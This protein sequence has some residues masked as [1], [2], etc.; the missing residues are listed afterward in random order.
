MNL[1]EVR[2]E[3]E[4][5]TLL[6]DT[7]NTVVEGNEDYIYEPPTGASCYYLHDGKPSCIWGHVLVG[8]DVPEAT[9][10]DLEF[11]NIAQVLER[12]AS[13]YEALTVRLLK[14]AE[15][16]Q[17]LQDGTAVTRPGQRRTWGEVRDAFVAMA[18]DENETRFEVTS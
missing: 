12:V 7:L 1:S 17:E 11:H 10:K 18:N 5:R 16:S 14:A 13:G 2:T 6:T 4:L 3:T 8:L 9:I 15:Y